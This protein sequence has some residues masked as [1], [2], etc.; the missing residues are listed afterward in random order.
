[1]R[2]E[3]F[4]G[5][6]RDIEFGRRF[7]RYMPNKYLPDLYDESIDARFL[8]QFS[9]EWRCNTDDET[10]YPL[11]ANYDLPA[12]FTPPRDVVFT[13][14]ETSIICTKEDIDDSRI[15]KKSDGGNRF[16]YVDGPYFI[17]DYDLLYNED[18]TI[19]LEGTDGRRIFLEL[20]KF[21]DP[22]R[23]AANGD[24]S[25][26]GIRDAYIFRI[27]EMYLIAAEAAWKGAAGD[28]AYAG[29]LLP[30]AESRALEG[31][32]GAE[33]LSSYGVNSSAD[34]SL[35]FFLDE[36]AREFPGE[37]MRWFDL[38]RALNPAD[39]VARIKQ[40]NE[41]VANLENYHYFRP[42]PQVQLDALE[43]SVFPQND[44]Y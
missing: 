34:L 17:L 27:A 32:T 39:F 36:R 12:G 9:T 41:D 19:N 15:A 42:I 25:Q 23:S 20:K 33:I 22:E 1:M 24:G 10:T 37:Q 31:A 4:E 43:G 3:L 18:G 44:G 5:M 2:Y 40:Y 8:G 28:D 30:L 35:N 14:G 21:D 11:Y 26:R 29:F 13:Q 7:R 16:L 6:I 38:R